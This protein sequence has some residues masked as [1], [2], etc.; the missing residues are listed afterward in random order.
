M[1]DPNTQSST[2]TFRKGTAPHDMDYILSSNAGA[3]P[4]FSARTRRQFIRREGIQP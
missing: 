4:G 3:D 1:E 2:K